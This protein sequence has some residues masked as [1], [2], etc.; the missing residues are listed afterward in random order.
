M[1][2]LELVLEVLE[3]SPN[4]METLGFL[5]GR[6]VIVD[7]KVLD[8]NEFDWAG[9]LNGIVFEVELLLFVV[10]VVVLSESFGEVENSSIQI[11]NVYIDD[12]L[13]DDD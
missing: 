5:N 6:V 9:V 13:N 7:V 2:E 8:E 3:R 1:E 12:E 4:R 10:V 11:Y